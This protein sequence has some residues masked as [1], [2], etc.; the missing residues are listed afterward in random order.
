MDDPTDTALAASVWVGLTLCGLLA[1]RLAWN[2]SRKRFAMKQSR[3]NENLVD[4]TGEPP[5]V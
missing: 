1:C 3:S 2:E 5:E 4:L